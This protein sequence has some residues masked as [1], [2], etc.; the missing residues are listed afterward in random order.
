MSG[1]HITATLGWVMNR[2][3][4]MPDRHY[5]GIGMCI[6][7]LDRG[8]QLTREHVVPY[9]L[10]GRGEM[11][12]KKGSCIAC[13]GLM[14]KNF[15]NPAMQN[16]LRDAR[17]ILTLKRRKRKGQVPL[18]P[19]PVIVSDRMGKQHVV[20]LPADQHP[21]FVAWSRT[22]PAGR[23]VNQVRGSLMDGVEVWIGTLTPERA[24]Y[25]EMGSTTAM[26]AGA[27]PML[28]AKA[29]YTFAIAELGFQSFDGADIRGLLRG[30]RDDIFDFVG[31]ALDGE[32]ALNEDGDLH[33]FF[34]RNRDG[35]LVVT[36]HLFASFGAPAWDVALGPMA[37]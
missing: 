18:L 30:D 29:A 20:Q 10:S 14:N 3:M 34:W 9:G 4:E 16:D 1:D 36:V 13:N 28:V 35:Q 11:F 5:E 8:K 12:I 24:K 33:H 19:N 21:G 7:C 37:A 31:G 2:N 23:L 15:E 26:V 25:R 6:Y 32:Q 17:A 22:K 27:L